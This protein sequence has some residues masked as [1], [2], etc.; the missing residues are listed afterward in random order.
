[1]RKSSQGHCGAEG[2]FEGHMPRH[3]TMQINRL[4]ILLQPIQREHI[5]P[6][7]RRPLQPQKQPVSRNSPKDETQHGDQFQDL[8]LQTYLNTHNPN[9]KQNDQNARK[10]PQSNAHDQ[11]QYTPQTNL[12]HIRRRQESP[13]RL[14]AR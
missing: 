1:M 3:R 9:P 7:G 11:P 2:H 5:I 6:L 10:G 8:N 13:A 12:S 14:L 4:E